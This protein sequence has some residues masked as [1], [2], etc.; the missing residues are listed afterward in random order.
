MRYRFRL[1]QQVGQYP[2]KFRSIDLFGDN[3]AVGIQQ[4]VV[5]DG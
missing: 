5:G 3:F 1:F 2:V 4:E